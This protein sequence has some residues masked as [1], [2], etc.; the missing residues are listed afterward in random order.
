[1][2]VKVTDG[3]GE[4]YS[5]SQLR[6][7]QPNTSFPANPS[8]ELLAN[9]NVYPLVEANPN[10]GA[11]QKKVHSWTPELIDSVWTLNH[12]AV[13]MSVSEIAARDAVTAAN[14][15]EARDKLLA[16]VDWTGASDLT[17]SS[18]MTAYR[19]ALRDIPAHEDFP[20]LAD[21][22]WPTKP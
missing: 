3:N 4:R 17:M 19:Q 15:R 18:D 10:V 2:Y 9:F 14:V 7:D 11:N 12:Q 20:N 1:M 8:D 5:V 16:E 13:D 22:D 6:K 21:S